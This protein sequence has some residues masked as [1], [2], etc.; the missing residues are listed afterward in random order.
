MKSDFAYRYQG[1]RLS[2]EL[3]E[4]VCPVTPDQIRADMRRAGLGGMS[5]ESVVGR[6]I[7][8]RTYGRIPD[9][10]PWRLIEP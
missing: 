7:Y 10:R 1:I 3:L 4:R 5:T 9:L 6:H 8:V 2:D